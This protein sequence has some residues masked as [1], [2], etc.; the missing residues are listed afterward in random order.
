MAFPAVVFLAIGMAANLMVMWGCAYWSSP[1]PFDAR[2]LGAKRMEFFARN[3]ADYVQ[4]PF[5]SM[6][7]GMAF[8]GRGAEFL[9]ISIESSEREDIVGPRL[10]M[11]PCLNLIRAGWPCLGLEGWI[12]EDGTPGRPAFLPSIHYAIGLPNNYVNASRL[13]MQR[14]LPLKP[15]WPGLL[16]NWV[17]WTAAV[18]MIWMIPWTAR[19]IVRRIRHR[20]AACGYPV[21]TSPV[22][23]ECGRRVTAM[24]PR[25]NTD[26]R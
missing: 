14:V 24:E 22:C 4:L 12:L 9:E 21:G 15:M 7:V 13:S 11:M 26:E 5:D 2:F 6:W 18:V 1:S 10:S 23:T 25:I 3:R 17:F 20:C 16:K 19:R 8:H